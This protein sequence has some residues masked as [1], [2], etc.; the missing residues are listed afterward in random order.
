M[1]KIVSFS[2]L[3]TLFL[4]FLKYRV[5]FQGNFALVHLRPFS[6]QIIVNPYNDFLFRWARNFENFR[7]R[8]G[9]L[10]QTSKKVGDIR[11]VKISPKEVHLKVPRLPIYYHLE[12]HE[13]NLYGGIAVLGLSNGHLFCNFCKTKSANFYKPND[14]FF[15]H[16]V[17]M[18]VPT[19]DAVTRIILVSPEI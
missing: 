4:G 11:F 8:E 19:K 14:H 17:Q 7:H 10:D 1:T 12:K 18:S 16:L 13:A 15:G 9:H 3:F 2:I 6:S 5:L